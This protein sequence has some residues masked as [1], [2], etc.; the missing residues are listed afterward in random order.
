[1]PKQ[2]SLEQSYLLLI[3][4]LMLSKRRVLELGAEF[5]LT[6]M[7]AMMLFLLDHPRPMNNFKKVFNC[8]A[9]NITGLVDG[10]EQK[11][12]ASRY[13]NQDDRRIKMVRLDAKGKRVRSDLVSRLATRDSSIFSQLSP[14]EFQTF[15]QLLQKITTAAPQYE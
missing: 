2:N 6:G 15:I 14:T 12:L 3:E 9:S 1:M 7:Q 11:K 13:E 10:L 8:D 5:D 4:F